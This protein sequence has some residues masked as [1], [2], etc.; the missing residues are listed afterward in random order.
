MTSLLLWRLLDA[1]G[2]CADFTGVRTGVDGS[3]P[4]YEAFDQ[5]HDGFSGA[6]ATEVALG[7]QFLPGVVPTADI[8]LLHLGTNDI[9]RPVLFGAPVDLQAAEDALVV[10]IGLVRASNPDVKVALAQIMPMNVPGTATHVADWN[11]VRLPSVVQRTQQPNSPVVLVDQNSGFVFGQHYRDIV[12]PNEA[13]EQRLAANWFAA[14]TA[15][16]WLSPFVSCASALAPGCAGSSTTGPPRLVSTLPQQGSVL[17]LTVDNVPPGTLA[18]IGVIGLSLLSQPTLV[19]RCRVH[20][21][22]DLVTVWPLDYFSGTATFT[23][24]LSAAT[25][26]LGTQLYAQAVTIG[27]DPNSMPTTN[28]LQLIVGF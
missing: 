4:K 12:H 21:A 6:M 18:V 9:L 8:V 3:A 26:A 1:A 25:V 10:A 17:A 2:L 19:P 23:M 28:G 5:D 14:L 22:L 20:P 13:G 16:G 11:N 15:H 27:P 7:M 24:P